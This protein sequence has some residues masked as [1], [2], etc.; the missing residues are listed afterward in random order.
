M[1]PDLKK[2]QINSLPNLSQFMWYNS[3]KSV[4]LLQEVER[5][6]KKLPL[7]SS[8]S[9]SGVAGVLSVLSVLYEVTDEVSESRDSSSNPKNVSTT[10]L[11]KISFFSY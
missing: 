5:R 2:N 7:T 8:K 4:F 1:L 11:W 6:T 9:S 3:W 10:C